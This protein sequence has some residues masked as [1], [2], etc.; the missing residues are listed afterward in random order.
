MARKKNVNAV[1]L[2]RRGGIIRSKMLSPEQRSA[3]ARLGGL[4]SWKN[5]RA[6][7]KEADGPLPE[8]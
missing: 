7:G 1:A 8:D 2:G 4:A 3:I 5:K 6:Q